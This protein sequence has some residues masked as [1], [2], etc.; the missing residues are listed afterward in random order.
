MSVA[1]SVRSDKIQNNYKH[2]PSRI[3][4]TRH[5]SQIFSEILMQSIFQTLFL[6]KNC[7]KFLVSSSVAK[8]HHFYAAP[9]PGKNFDAAPAPTL[10]YSKI[11]FLKRTTVKFKHKLKLSYPYDS[12]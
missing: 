12:V 11:K 3:C 10:L 4:R 7:I 8:P 6:S 1:L 5:D 2:T 9:A